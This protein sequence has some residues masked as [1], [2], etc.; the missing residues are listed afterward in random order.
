MT[1]S[2]SQR[3]VEMLP[4]NVVSTFSGRNFR[5]ITGQPLSE[6]RLPDLP[7]AQL[8]NFEEAAKLTS[9]NNMRYVATGLETVNT[10]GKPV[11]SWTLSLRPK[12]GSALPD[13]T[14]ENYTR[15]R[16]YFQAITPQNC[17]MRNV[18]IRLYTDGQLLWCGQYQPQPQ[19]PP[20]LTR[21]FRAVKNVLPCFGKSINKSTRVVFKTKEGQVSGT[22]GD[23]LGKPFKLMDGRIN[24]TPAATG[25]TRLTE[26]TYADV[27]RNIGKPYRFVKGV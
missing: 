1:R 3:N 12:V 6:I 2:A 9:Y 5:N 15:A 14:I 11:F 19:Q 23:Q 17:R 10:K 8:G 16:A 25:K 22:I 21:V 24:L 20:V 27:C 7:E 13:V 4:Q 26:K 18:N